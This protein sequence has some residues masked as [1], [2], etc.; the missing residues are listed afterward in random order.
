MEAMLAE[1]QLKNCGSQEKNV[2]LENFLLQK[3][4]NGFTILK[5]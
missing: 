5:A 1:E 4:D 3:A 2:I